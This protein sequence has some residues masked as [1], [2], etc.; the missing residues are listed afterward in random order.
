MPNLNKTRKAI[1]GSITS[2][3]IRLI[4]KTPLTPNSLT[5]L[6]FCITAASAVLVVTEHLVAAG[7]TLLIAGLFDMLDG[8]L[9][10]FTG[11]ASRFG[12]ILDSSLDRVSEAILLI[13]LL[14]VYAGNAQAWE[15][16]LCGVALLASFMVSYIRARMEGLGIE[17][18]AGF[19]TRPE[20]VILMVLGLLLSSV[21]YALIIAIGLIAVLSILS[22]G[23][24]MVFAWRITSAS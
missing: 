2:P 11:K 13:A 22:A 14:A 21:P 1:A 17:C 15:S 4:A 8:A 24:R 16:A 10:R 18:T 6:G 3:I 20:R 19:F 23:Q 7:V 9:A 5:W 12:A